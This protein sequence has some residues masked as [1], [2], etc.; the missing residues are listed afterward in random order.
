MKEKLNKLLNQPYFPISLMVLIALVVSIQ[1][2]IEGERFIDGGYY[3]HYNNYLIFKQSFYHLIQNKDLYAYYATEHFD[4][5][6]YSPTFAILF[7]PFALLPDFL[8]LSLWNVFNLLVFVFA[9]LSLPNFSVKTI[10]LI[11]LLSLLEIITTAQ[12]EQSNTLMIA[13]FLFAFSSLEKRKYFL[14][15][16][17]LVISIY[18][19]LYGI[20]AFSM[21]LFYPDKIKLAAYSIFW[22]LVLFSLPLVLVDYQQLVFNYKSWLALLTNEHDQIYG[23]SVMGWLSTWFRLEI[24]KFIPVLIGIILFCLPLLKIA[25][26]KYY[27]FRLLAL[28]SVLIWVVIFNHRAESA[29]YI[30][31]YTGIAIWFML[32]KQGLWEKL[33]MLGAFILITLSPTDLFPK[34][35]REEYV[36]GYTLKAVPAILIWLLILVR[37]LKPQNDELTNK[38]NI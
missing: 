11:V 10:S 23:I 28:C 6:K 9:L 8:G 12:N 16:L 27:S 33:L 4:L 22:L 19:K 24:S 21:F 18:L 35:I 38:E 20:V 31:A 3:T 17:F 37:M 14:A 25:N 32:G 36:Q 13:L 29:S 7:A 1:S 15:T 26:Y 30:I 2:L 5:F 34:Y